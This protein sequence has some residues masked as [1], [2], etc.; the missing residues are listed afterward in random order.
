MVGSHQ[1]RVTVDGIPGVS[2]GLV[3]AVI[4]IEGQP[5]RDWF[6]E[7]EIPKHWETIETMAKPRSYSWRKVR[8]VIG[9]ESPT[10]FPGHWRQRP[11]D[12]T[13]TL[14]GQP[15]TLSHFPF[16][17]GVVQK[18]WRG[19]PQEA[20]D[21]EGV[22]VVGE[23]LLYDSPLA[24][25]AWR[26][27]ERGIFGAV[28]PILI[29]PLAD[30][31]GAGYVYAI[32]L[33]DQPVCPGAKILKTWDWREQMVEEVL[34]KL[35]AEEREALEELGEIECVMMEEPGAGVPKPMDC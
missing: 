9:D 24:D 33:T 27:I 34:A 5:L 16:I 6:A 8:F 15:L 21:A 35:P 22:C 25:A 28:S 29:R 2:F 12:W 3:D 11:Q 26:G 4:H 30:P 10:H 17:I 20:P 14:N 31:P 1:G 23:A 32:G 13:Y 19:S 18:V 7:L